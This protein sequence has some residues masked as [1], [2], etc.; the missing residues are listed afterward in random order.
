MRIPLGRSDFL[1]SIAET[2]AIQLLNRYFESDPTNQEDQVALLTRPAL[3]KWIELDTSPV[4]GLYSQPGSFNE[5]L[6]AVGGD[7]VYSIAQD[8]TVTS[9]GTLTSDSGAV[10]MAATDTY[11]FIADGEALHFYTTNAFSQGTL[12]ATGAIS[13]G[14]QVRIGAMYYQFTSGDVDAG[15]P[16]GTSGSPWL[17]ALGSQLSTSLHNLF[18]AIANTGEAGTDYSTALTASSE[19]APASV[20]STALVVRAISPGSGANSIATTETGA[21]L[22]WGAATLAGGGATTFSTVTVPDN[23]GI[24]S[25]GVIASFTICVVA[26]G[27]G[28]NGR[29][30][31]IEPGETIIDPLNFATAE[32]SPDPVW[33]VKVVGDQFWLPGSSTNEVWYPTGDPLAPF[34]RQQGRLFDKGIWEGTI[35]QIKD[36][37]M[38]VGTDGVV[39]QIADV[40]QGVSP[41]GITQRIREAISAQRSL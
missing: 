9:I 11:L 18:D 2:P 10:S 34:V 26:Q 32:R 8:E 40:P 4:R 28:K 37:V 3:R 20:S 29:F 31:W 27:Q 1:R 41:P 33:E 12:T 23:D 25:V 22:S 21:T 15:A 7:T 6:F 38:A 13:S 35:I 19:V 5:A 24:V 16:A 30:Y 36:S 17:V 39:Y 14:V